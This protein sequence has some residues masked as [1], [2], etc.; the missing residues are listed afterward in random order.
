V[1]AAV[2][3]GLPALPA[4]V[5]AAVVYA[6]VVLCTRALPDELRDLLPRR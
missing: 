5:V 1:A 2:V 4:S 6:I 3:S